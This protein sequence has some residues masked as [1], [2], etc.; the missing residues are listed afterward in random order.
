MGM[1][2][3]AVP[4]KDWVEDGGVVHPGNQMKSS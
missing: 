2:P 1:Q 4:K 3:T